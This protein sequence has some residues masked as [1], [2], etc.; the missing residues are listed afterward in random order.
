MGSRAEH[1]MKGLMRMVMMRLE[2][3]SMLRL[4]I[5]AGT[6]H[7]NPMTNGMNDLPCSPMRC[8]ILSMM[9]A[10]RAIYPESSMNEMHR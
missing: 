9:N 7:P 6:L 5:M 1:D 3:L 10:A 8:I 4:D 2:R